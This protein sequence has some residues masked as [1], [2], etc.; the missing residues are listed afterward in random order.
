[1]MMNYVCIGSDFRFGIFIEPNECSVRIPEYAGL[2]AYFY[3]CLDFVFLV[4]ACDI[5]PDEFNASCDL[6][7]DPFELLDAEA[8]FLNRWYLPFYSRNCQRK[9]TRIRPTTP[10]VGK[11]IVPR[12]GF[13]VV[14]ISW[15]SND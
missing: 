9:P 11:Y 10:G 14:D 12:L 13:S 7:D 1:M 4:D 6:T 5:N 15:L 3:R 8:F 2:F